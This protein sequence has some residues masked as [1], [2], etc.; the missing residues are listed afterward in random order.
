[1]PIPFVRRETLADIRPKSPDR[2]VSSA[3][4]PKI[5]RALANSLRREAP[6]D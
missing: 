4:P 5:D 1:M 6:L 2:R 3:S